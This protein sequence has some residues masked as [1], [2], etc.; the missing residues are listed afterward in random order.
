[1]SLEIFSNGRNTLTIYSRAFKTIW[2][3]LILI[4][5][6]SL[7]NNCNK[8]TITSSSKKKCFGI[9]YQENN[10]S[11]LVTKIPLSFMLKLSSEGREIESIGFNFQMAYVP[12]VALSSKKK[13]KNTS[14]ISF[15]V[16]NTPHQHFP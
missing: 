9:K 3:E 14:K 7:K 8:N 6:P 10:G 16:I 4:D 15:V 12:L 1:M 2:K 13:P 11:N 5:T